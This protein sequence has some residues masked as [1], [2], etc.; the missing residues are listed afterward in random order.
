MKNQDISNSID[1]ISI[2]LYFILVV[3]G[4]MTIYSV[5]VPA[6]QEYTFDFSLNY[7]RQMIFMMITIPIIFSILFI[8]S[9]VFERFS[10]VFYGI[11]IAL[12]LGLFVFGVSKKGQTN[13]YNLE[14]LVFSLPSL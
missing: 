7:G 14:G 10:P 1:W 9:K 2:L 11:G 12:L 5:T 6:N 13:W 3:F 8:D 4:W